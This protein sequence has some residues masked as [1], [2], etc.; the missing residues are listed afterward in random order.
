MMLGSLLLHD[1]KLRACWLSGILD[2][3]ATVNCPI[4]W[5][6]STV[7]TYLLWNSF[8]W[9]TDIFLNSFLDFSRGVPPL[10]IFLLEGLGSE[11]LRYL[12]QAYRY[13]WHRL[14]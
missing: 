3:K 7:L 9:V 14:I 5:V 11:N 4:R 8:K 2:N 10:D 12:V 6:M 13:V 1:H